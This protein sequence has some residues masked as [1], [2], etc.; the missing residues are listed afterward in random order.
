[1]TRVLRPRGALGFTCWTSPGW[2]PTMRAVIPDFAYPAAMS[3]DWTRSEF[4]QSTLTDL[5]LTD[6]KVVPLDFTTEERDV[7]ALIEIQHV[8][9]AK[10]AIGEVG[11]RL[12]RYL[13]DEFAREGQIV[14]KWQ[15]LIVT[16]IK[17]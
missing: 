2:Y 9:F 1:M 17:P 13:R 8:L 16:A 4:I 15:A 12:D 7:E 10:I 3:G 5:G 14:W 11:E 6:V